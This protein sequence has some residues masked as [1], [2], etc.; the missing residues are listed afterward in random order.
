MKTA[1]R[2]VIAIALLLA[3][4][5]ALR[6]QN[7]NPGNSGGGNAPIAIPTYGA[8]LGVDPALTSGSRLSVTPNTPANENPTVRGATGVTIVK[9]DSST[10]SG[11][12]RATV[13]QKT[14]SFASDAPG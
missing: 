5:A 14:G 11:D 1:F 13:D 2:P 3:P 8:E 10:I 7:Y 12:R 9:G 4:T 6:A